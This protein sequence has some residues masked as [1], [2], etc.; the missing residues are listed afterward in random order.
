MLEISS[1]VIFKGYSFLTLDEPR[2]KSEMRSRKSENGRFVPIRRSIPTSDFRL[3]PLT[4]DRPKSRFFQI[5]D[6]DA[7]GKKAEQ[8]Y[9]GNDKMG[10][11]SGTFMETRPK[12]LFTPWKLSFA[13][14]ILEG[15]FLWANLNGERHG[16]A[17]E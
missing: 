10:R 13:G 11:V 4:S 14:G 15:G 6:K 3:P 8:V 1:L 16:Y 17:W 2:V 5:R 9:S 7:G 12:W